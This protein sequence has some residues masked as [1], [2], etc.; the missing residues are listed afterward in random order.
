M[1]QTVFRIR[2]ATTDDFQS[3]QAL[4]QSMRFAADDL[5]KRLTEFQVV[6]SA[7]GAIVGAVGLQIN[8]RHALL[9][10][11]GYTDFAVA[12][13]A[14]ELLWERIR[15]IASHHGVFRLWT[16]EQSPFWVRWG[17]QPATLENLERLPA[18]WNG[19]GEPW[20]TIQI[21]DEEALAAM[22]KEIE[23]FKAE[24]K[25]RTEE[26]L[27]QART[28]TTTIT[29]IA[30]LVGAALLGVAFFI[31]VRRGLFVPGH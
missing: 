25:K 31:L 2:R 26:A 23:L 24:G 16:R 17:F 7:D 9:H 21:K 8:G 4:W 6:E 14:R 1:S 18:E 29:V 13:A 3:L 27:A 10:S 30:F 28:W 12:D 22:D 20:L 11:E 15:T 19:P 5:E